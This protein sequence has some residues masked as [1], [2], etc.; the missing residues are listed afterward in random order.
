MMTLLRFV[1]GIGF[2]LMSVSVT[3]SDSSCGWIWHTQGQ[4]RPVFM[5]HENKW[6]SY[7]LYVPSSYRPGAPLILD[8]HGQS[9]TRN[10]Q[11]S[12]SCWRDL[13]ER[14]GAVV[15]YPQALSF[16]PTWDAG[17]YCCYP[18]GHDDEG[19]ALQI[20]QCLAS[21]RESG[22]V[23]DPQ[24]I[25]AVGYSNGA[26]LAGY[27]ACNHSDVFAGTALAAQ[28]FPYR[29]AESCRAET[30]GQR[31]P[32]FPVVEM[33]G[34][35][36]FIVPFAFSLGW[37]ASAQQSVLRWAAANGC[38]GEPQTY[39]ACEDPASGD[40]CVWGQSYCHRYDNCEGGVAVTQC[41]LNDGHAIF[42]NQQRYNFCTAAWHQFQAQP[43]RP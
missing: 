43:I 11:Y 5:K 40:G 23:I 31:K 25:F 39:D 9:S 37:S 28:S 3:A 20:V 19:F 8:F 2:M 32:P 1:C 16:P 4:A 13:A 14:E 30:D 38:V 22:L 24:R 42:R 10:S 27:L 36:D 15:A 7:L 21:V 17:D 33:R 18:R 35:W 41:A 6:R 12:L 26:A 29:N 34:K